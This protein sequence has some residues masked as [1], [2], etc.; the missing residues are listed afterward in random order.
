MV[1][2]RDSGAASPLASTSIPP[3]PLPGRRSLYF[4]HGIYGRGRNWAGVAGKVVAARDDWQAVLVDLR[5]H[6]D[7]APHA[8]PHTVIE[9][10]KDVARLSTF[11]GRRVEGI[12]G[13]S[14][15]GKVALQFASVAPAGLRQVWIIDSTPAP[16]VPDGSAWRMLETVRATPGPYASRQTAAN[17]LVAAGFPAPVATWMASNA[18]WRDGAYD[19]R[20]DFDVMEGLLLDFFRLDLWSVIETPPPGSSC[21]S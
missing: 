5:G 16:R 19:W 4:L 14:F 9:A 12:L 15:G 8:A 20:L 18:V 3:G 1:A 13:H 6:G 21:T 11:L 7:S 10:A 2:H 17:V